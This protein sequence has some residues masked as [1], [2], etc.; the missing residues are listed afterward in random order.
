MS[1]QYYLGKH[2]IPTGTDNAAQP[3]LKNNTNSLIDMSRTNH[4]FGLLEDI[5]RYHELAARSDEMEKD[6][7]PKRT[8]V[9]RAAPTRRRGKKLALRRPGWNSEP[10][11]ILLEKPRKRPAEEKP[12]TRRLRSHKEEPQQDKLCPIA[13]W[14]PTSFELKVTK[15]NS[16]QDMVTM[17]RNTDSIDFGMH[18]GL[19]PKNLEAEAKRFELELP[20]DTWQLSQGLMSGDIHSFFR[21]LS[22]D[23]PLV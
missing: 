7:P 16:Y 15:E 19:L 12:V 9:V 11:E 1:T 21:M 2:I 5:L 20:A 3:K 14:Q 8:R 6:I 17:V 22:G 10:A 18:L 4:E 13:R 23:V